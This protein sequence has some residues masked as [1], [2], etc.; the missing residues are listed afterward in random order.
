MLSTRTTSQ[1]RRLTSVI[2][3][4]VTLSLL[5]L[6]H[7][8]TAFAQSPAVVVTGLARG[9]KGDAVKTLQQA[10]VSQG[11]A[12]SG[13]VDGVFGAGTEAAL[14]EFQ[15]RNGLSPSG[16]V[17]LATALALGLES[18]P[19]MGLAQGSRGEAVKD[20][21]LR[22]GAAGFTPKGGADGVFGAGTATSLGAFQK[23]KG[24]SV[25]A[26][27]D[28]ATAAA[29]SSVQPAAPAAQPAQPTKP[30]TQPAPSPAA[31]GSLSGLT[32]GS[33]GDAVKR[34]QQI[35]IDNG[36]TV[37]GG[38]D[39][40]YGV[41]T[42]NAVRSFQNANA[43]A[44]TGNV[45]E[46]T[47]AALQA[48]AKPAPTP[49]D[50]TVT[51]PFVGL[52]YGSL[53]SDV[54]SLQQALIAAG[55]AVR[56]GADGVFGNATVAAVKELQARHGIAQSGKVDAATAG[57]LASRQPSGSVTNTLVGLKAGALGNT[58]KQLQDALIAAGVTVR[59]GADGIFGPATSA[60]LKSFQTSQGLG[61]TGEVDQATADALAKPKAPV[62]G[63]AGTS[64]WASY[65]EKG[66][67]VTALQSALVSAGITVR[68]GVDG[69]FGS[70]TSAA[71][72]EFQRQKGLKVTGKVDN[73]TAQ[74]LGL[75]AT[76]APT[77]PDPASVSISVFPVQG[78]CYFGDSYGY[79]RSGGRTHLGVD[80]IAPEGNLLYAVA[81]GKISKI[82][83]DYPG[84]LSGNG[85]RLTMADG[86]YFFYAHLTSFADGIELGV[87]VRAG[88]VL[89]YVGRTGNAGTTHLHFE[90]HPKGGAAVNPYPIVKAIDA[91]NVTTPL[92]Q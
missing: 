45:D 75:G 31:P 80:I 29:L 79:P 85:L 8:G 68:G 77:T 26:T 2:A 84:S 13:G 43:I 83:A 39:G 38:A 22:L 4:G 3:A 67:R 17:D 63:A 69:D 92:G 90:I 1:I 27:V 30:A 74:A 25:T 76:P 34:V 44:L 19:L 6:P 66:A 11:I 23:S 73:A 57:A 46:A 16:S 55:I 81:D 35:L 72:M 82:Y 20:L 62:N 65:G 51:S 7:A 14:K 32:I 47:A 24:L 87:P 56:G 41:L 15:S 48:S 49:H 59:G 53:G 28:A 88:Q 50:P 18:S 61:A 5:P 21:Q 78:K 12:V 33:R 54:S 10:L 70:G 52:Q 42:A 9:A 71:I 36:F 37:V 86:T 91:C 58:V 64:G 89:G 60:A 40:V